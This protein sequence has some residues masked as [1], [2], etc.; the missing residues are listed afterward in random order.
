MTIAKG[1]CVSEPMPVESAAGSRPRQATRAVIMMGRSLRSDASRVTVRIS[2][3][4]MKAQLVDGDKSP[5]AV[6]TPINASMPSPDDALNGVPVSFS[7]GRAPTGT[8]RITPRTM[9]TRNLK[10]S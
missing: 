1:F 4:F 5:L 3:F 7:A 9:T 6:S 8:V 2:I 10:L